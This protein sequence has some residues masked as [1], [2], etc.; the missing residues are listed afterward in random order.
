M[1]DDELYLFDL[2]GFIVIEG[3]L[4][5]DEVDRCNQAIDHQIAAD[6]AKVI[7]RP[8]A[9]T[10]DGGSSVMAGTSRRLDMQGDM[11]AWERPWCDPFRD[12]IVHPRLK[13]YLEA[14]LEE[15][16]RVDGGVEFMAT[17]PGVEGHVLH[18]GGVERDNFSDDYFFK[19]GRIYSGMIVAELALADEGPNDGGIALIPASHKANLRCPDRMRL[20]E[21]YQEHIRKVPVKAGDV[22]LFYRNDDPR[23][24]VLAGE[25]SAPHD[26]H[27]ILPRVHRLP[28][29]EAI[30]GRSRIH[31]RHDR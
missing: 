22:V 14:I 18:G 9:G 15:G 12:L 10:L 31:G 16:F 23:C 13:P 3:L 2:N 26:S 20:T 24:P 25:S 30:T 5:A 17:H 7:E 4:S 29:D 27:P 28:Q 19:A 1:T 21:A 6:V 8:P 11:L